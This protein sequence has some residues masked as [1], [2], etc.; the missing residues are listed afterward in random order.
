MLNCSTQLFLGSFSL[1]MGAV[2][3]VMMSEVDKYISY[4]TWIWIFNCTNSNISFPNYILF[5]N[6]HVDI[7]HQHQGHSRKLG[8][9]GELVWIMGC[10][11]Y[12]QLSH[13]LEQT[14]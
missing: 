8:Y 6:F 9:P 4:D 13:D 10:F 14:R 3:W 1:G 7:S 12:F 11:P 5:M 2:P